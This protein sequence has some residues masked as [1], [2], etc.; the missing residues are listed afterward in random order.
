[1]TT[2]LGAELGHLA[3][4]GPPAPYDDVRLALLDAVIAAN[5]DGRIDQKAWEAAFSDAARS[6]RL[7]LLADAETAVAA[8]ATRSRYPARRLRALLPDADAADT[9]LHRLLAEGIPLERLENAADNPVNRRAR[10][11]ALEMAWEGAT[12]VAAAEQARWRLVAGQ[13]A[14]WRRPTAPLWVI[15]VGLLLVAA[16][17]AAWLGGT[18]PA[19]RWFRP[20]NAFWWRLWP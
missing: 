15:S 16:L 9:L 18:L 1:M 14:N 12:R 7:R 5:A 19:P 11:A 10:A 2:P 4:P 20:I 13:V 6:L 3:A 8:A 17:A